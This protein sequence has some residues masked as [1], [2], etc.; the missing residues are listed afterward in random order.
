MEYHAQWKLDF[1]E[2]RDGDREENVR[3]CEG[4]FVALSMLADTPA[5]T[6]LSGWSHEQ[7]AWALAGAG[8]RLRRKRRK[9]SIAVCALLRRR[10]SG[11]LPLW[12]KAGAVLCSGI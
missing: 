9:S 8:A 5:G 10:C 2:Y 11:K 1:Y 3:Q 12:G 6:D 7:V 4:N